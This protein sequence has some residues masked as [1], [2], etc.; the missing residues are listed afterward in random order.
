M[1]VSDLKQCLQWSSCSLTEEQSWVMSF[2]VTHPM[3]HGL[4]SPAPVLCG[5]QTTGKWHF[6]R[7]DKKKV[8]TETCARSSRGLNLQIKALDGPTMLSFPMTAMKSRFLQSLE[9][10]YRASRGLPRMWL[11]RF[12]KLSDK[13][14]RT[15]LC[16]VKFKVLICCDFSVSMIIHVQI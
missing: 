16:S 6:C 10:E 8:I 7:S 2:R 9:I 12:E 1:F 13:R 11:W 14:Q 3:S 15:S 4:T 5:R